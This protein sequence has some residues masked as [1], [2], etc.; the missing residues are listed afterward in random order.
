M[1][2][3]YDKA[4][5]RHAKKETMECHTAMQSEFLATIAEE[6][7]R[8]N[9]R[10]NNEMKV[11]ETLCYSDEQP[12]VAEVADETDTSVG[13]VIMVVSDYP[14]YFEITNGKVNTYL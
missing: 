9:D 13:F 7:V 10:T 5:S 2:D 6:L 1:T 11:L 3:L 14:G 4:Y 12:T 8:F